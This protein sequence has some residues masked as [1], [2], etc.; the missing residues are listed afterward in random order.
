MK[1]FSPPLRATPWHTFLS[2][3]RYEGSSSVPRGSWWTSQVPSP[4]RGL[5]AAMPKTWLPRVTAHA[6]VSLRCDARLSPAA[7]ITDKRGRGSLSRRSRV[8]ARLLRPGPPKSAYRETSMGWSGL[9]T[10][11]LCLL[12]VSHDADE[13]LVDPGVSGQL[14]MKGGCQ[15]VI[16]SCGNRATVD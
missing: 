14:R 11:R 2:N 15:Y 10:I 5:A 13:K 7:S 9:I 12:G 8:K 6:Q 1:S 16:L 4:D 3:S